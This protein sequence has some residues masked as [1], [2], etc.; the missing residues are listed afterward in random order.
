MNRLVTIF[1]ESAELRVKNNQDLT[2]SF[3]QKN[4]DALLTFNGFDVLNSRGE[5]ANHQ[6]EKIAYKQY[7]KFDTTRKFLKQQQVDAE[8]LHELES[9]EKSLKYRKTKQLYP[10]A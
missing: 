8:D 7:E 1:L 9:L 4:V 3:W 5:W 6:A 2:F 10:K